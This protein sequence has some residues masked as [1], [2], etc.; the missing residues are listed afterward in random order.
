MQISLLEVAM[1]D[2]RIEQLSVPLELERVSLTGGE[3][4]LVEKD[5]V[6][7]R[8]ENV[9]KKV[10]DI[11]VETKVKA[12]VFCDRCLAPTQIELPVSCV[13]R[14]DTKK[15]AAQRLAELDECAFVTGMDLDIDMLVYFELLMNW[16][17]KILCRQ[18]CKGLCPRC[19]KNLNEGP[20][21]C[22]EEPKDP[23]MAVI[24]D[25]FH[26]FKEEV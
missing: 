6:Q 5:P 11:F 17:E 14:V 7:V 22:A 12:A 10:V 8:L 21:G 18:D 25:I 26:S 23:R 9:G 24:S 3:F 2:G 1:A 19:G 16:P 20:C 4:P 13:H 15:D